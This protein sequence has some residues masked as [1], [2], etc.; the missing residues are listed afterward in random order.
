MSKSSGSFTGS[1]SLAVVDTRVRRCLGF[2]G[3]SIGDAGDSLEFGGSSP[4][5]VGGSRAEPELEDARREP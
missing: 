1:G 5:S 3:S 2:S 4:G